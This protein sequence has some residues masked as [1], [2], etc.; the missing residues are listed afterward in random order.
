MEHYPQT[1]LVYIISRHVLAAV[2]FNYN[3]C[4]EVKKKQDSDE[5]QVSVIYPKFKNGEAI[6]RDVR[7]KPNYGKYPVYPFYLHN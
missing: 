2:H 3:L 5:T 7:I 6:V 4:R 1:A